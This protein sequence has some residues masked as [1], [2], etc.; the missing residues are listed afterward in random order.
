MHA[1]PAS[2]H[3]RYMSDFLFSAARLLFFITFTR[4]DK[5]LHYKVMINIIIGN[6]TR[7]RLAKMKMEVNC[8]VKISLHCTSTSNII[9]F[10]RLL[11]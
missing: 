3:L 11:N 7:K 8:L 2:Y 10:Q 5:Q 9:Y 4:Y 6:L 1:H